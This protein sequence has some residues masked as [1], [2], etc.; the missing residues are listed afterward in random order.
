MVL[1]WNMI[2][3]NSYRDKWNPKSSPIEFKMVSTPSTTYC[4]FYCFD[5][6]HPNGT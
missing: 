5:L 6:A 1:R 3:K 4:F 2:I